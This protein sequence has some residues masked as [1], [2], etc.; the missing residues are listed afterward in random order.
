MAIPEHLQHSL[1]MYTRHGQPTGGF[2]R[3]VLC[4]DLRDAV[5]RGDTVSRQALA[6][7]VLYVTANVPANATGS[8]DN[9]DAWIKQRG[10][11]A[12]TSKEAHAAI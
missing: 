10:L 7:L 8:D 1:E 2:L 9:V 3:A 6:D 11:Q 5:R 12:Y 4:N